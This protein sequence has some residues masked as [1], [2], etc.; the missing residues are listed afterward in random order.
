MS[1]LIGIFD[2]GFTKDGKGRVVSS[3]RFRIT[4]GEGKP[5][6]IVGHCLPV[7]KDTVVKNLRRLAFPNSDQEEAKPESSQENA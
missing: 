4:T 1:Q 2:D 3:I 6:D 5:D 7:Y